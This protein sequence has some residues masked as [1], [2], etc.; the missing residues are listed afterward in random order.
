MSKNLQHSKAKKKTFDLSNSKNKNLQFPKAKTKAFSFSNN[1]NN[2]FQ[3]PR[4]K[5]K[6]HKHKC[7]KFIDVLGQIY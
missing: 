2:N 6:T 1:N 4:A 7:M 5:T 3:P